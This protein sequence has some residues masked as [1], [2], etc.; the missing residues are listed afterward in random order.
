LKVLVTGYAGF[1]G[2]NLTRMLLR[3]LPSDSE[4][5]GLDAY[6][7]AAREKWVF[8]ALPDEPSP[9]FMATKV[10]LR[11]ADTVRAVVREWMPDQVYHLAA[12]SHVCRSI[13][14]PRAFAETNFMGTFNLLDALRGNGFKGRFLHVSTDEAFGELRSG[15]EP[16]DELTAV[17][18]RSPY[19]ASK[20][21]SDLMV[22][23]FCQ[24]YGIDAVITRSTNNFGPNQH[25]EKLIPR[26]I[27]RLMAGK[28][29][30]L[31]GDGTHRRDW[32]WVDDHCLALASVMR[33]GLSGN[34]Y[35]VGS[36]LE[37]SNRDVVTRV[38]DALRDELDWEGEL[39]L[40]FTGDRPTDDERYAVCTDKIKQL[41]WGVDSGPAYFRD[42]LRKTVRWYSERGF[43]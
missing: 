23:A 9:R 37:L 10:D 38:A 31:H 29:M 34:L 28:P 30:T 26:T 43:E 24:T 11:S 22:Q 15:D 18:P 4:V 40:E 17:R 41:G 20:A 19:A 2:S 6:T 16:F 27:Q 5:L 39:K 25:S 1:I 3:D 33:A 32:I 7:Y 13:E 12:E 8:E 36:G 21:A 35:C 14:G 42:R